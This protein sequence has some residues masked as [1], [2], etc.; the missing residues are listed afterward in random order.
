MADEAAAQ[1]AEEDHHHAL[2]FKIQIDRVHYTVHQEEMTG[3]QLRHVPP[4]GIPADRDLYEVCPGDDDR[5]IANN[6][7]V[8]IRDGLRFFTA[9][10]HINPGRGV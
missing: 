8:K 7:V 1:A 2:S 6:D 3:E 5:L 4:A 9:P 10:R